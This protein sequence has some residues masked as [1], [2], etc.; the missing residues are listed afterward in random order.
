MELKANANLCDELEVALLRTAGSDVI[1]SRQT[2][3]VA[4][5]RFLANELT[6]VDLVN[7]ANQVEAEVLSDR[8][9]YEAGYEKL[10]ATTLFYIASPEINGALDAA[11][12]RT[13]VEQLPTDG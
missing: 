9:D 2:L 11:L 7:W 12:C 10:L 6:S 5:N 4:L 8:I 3:R 1:V 13:Y